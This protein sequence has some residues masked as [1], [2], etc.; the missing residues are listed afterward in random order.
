MLA[1]RIAELEAQKKATQAE[2]EEKE[3]A[4]SDLA[5]QTAAARKQSEFGEKLG[6]H[7]LALRT[8]RA[9]KARVLVDL[10]IDLDAQKAATQAEREEK[11]R[12]QAK[13]AAKEKMLAAI[14]RMV[15]GDMGSGEHTP[16]PTP[17]GRKRQP[18]GEDASG[19]KKAR[20]EAGDGSTAGGVCVA[21]ALCDSYIVLP[22]PLRRCSPLS[23]YD[24]A[25]AF[26]VILQHVMCVLKLCSRKKRRRFPVAALRSFPVE[27]CCLEL[28]RAHFSQSL[29]IF[30][31]PLCSGGE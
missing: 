22:S 3:K 1:E 14:H 24:S 26:S 28:F 13:L 27:V 5:A 23:A 20:V 4:L 12:V 11:E 19:G 25:S 15:G 2:R 7:Q 17:K 6:A 8:E 10:T 30:T 31:S 21:L 16:T 18:G 29:T 9:D